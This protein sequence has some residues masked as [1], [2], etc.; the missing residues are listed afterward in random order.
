MPVGLGVGVKLSSVQD[1]EEA[2]ETAESVV[3]RCV[4]FIWAR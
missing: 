1:G 2:D 3:S 4:G